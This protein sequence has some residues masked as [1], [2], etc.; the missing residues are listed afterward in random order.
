MPAQ[1]LTTEEFI[2]LLGNALD[3]E[4]K[5]I[6]QRGNL[7]YSLIVRTDQQTMTCWGPSFS[8]MTEPD[9]ADFIRR[10]IEAQRR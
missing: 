4:L 3:W 6:G 5:I 1:N 10:V 2:T 7:Y 8:A 9:M